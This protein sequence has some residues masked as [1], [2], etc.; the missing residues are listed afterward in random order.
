[1]Q[2]PKASRYAFPAS[3]ILLVSIASTLLPDAYAV[4]LEASLDRETYYAGSSGTLTLTL[5]D[6][7]R[8]P[9]AIDDTR[10][11]LVYYRTGGRIVVDTYSPNNYSIAAGETIV[12]KVR[13]NVSAS[14]TP[15]Y[16]TILSQVTYTTGSQ[17]RTLSSQPTLLYV[18]SPYRRTAEQLSQE[19]KSLNANVTSLKV[20]VAGLKR[21]VDEI[22]ASEKRITT[23]N[24]KLRED[25][26]AALRSYDEVLGKYR[27]Q[28]ELYSK[29]QT[30]FKTLSEQ[31][32]LEQQKSTILGEKLRT[33]EYDNYFVNR[34]LIYY[35][36]LSGGVA[37]TA[38]IVLWFFLTKRI[39]VTR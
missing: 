6:I 30:D 20:E 22:S 17:R 13:F 16:A 2:H 26:Q 3:L 12:V 38:G 14:A 8:Q 37:A 24:Q 36:L 21:R 19:I 33:I 28:R 15:G 31:N 23:E 34:T 32:R 25:N 9:V 11:D 27:E 29:L 39:I 7:P 10:I 35:I 4:T 1:M 18:E 5:K